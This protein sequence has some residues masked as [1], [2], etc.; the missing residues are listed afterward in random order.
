MLQP[1]LTKLNTN[2]YQIPE[3]LLEIDAGYFVVRNHRKKTF[4]VHHKDQPH[5]TFCLT[6]PYA[7]L[8]ARTVEL[9]R[10]TSVSNMNRL[11]RE[12]DEHNQKLEKTMGNFGEESSEKT[13]EVLSY[14]NTHESREWVDEKAFSTRFL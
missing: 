7:E 10:K 4:E 8:D 14:L 12:M 1:H 6:V 13:K 3:R 11:I 9:V 2:V 5:T